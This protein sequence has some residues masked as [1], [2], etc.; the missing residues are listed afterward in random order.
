MTDAWTTEEWEDAIRAV[1]RRAIADPKFRTHAVNDARAAFAEASGRPPPAGVKFR[2]AEALEE[3]VL[4]L[5]KVIAA[6][7][8]L[9]EIDISRILFHSV[10]QQSIPPAITS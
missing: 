10:R 8:A 9:S 6:E 5:P 1:F 7:G 3:H 2:F 4:V